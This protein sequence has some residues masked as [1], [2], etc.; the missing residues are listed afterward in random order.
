MIKTCLLGLGR[1]GMVVAEH[2]IKSPEFDLVSVI[3][4]QGSLKVNRKLNKFINTEKKI[5]IKD[6]GS[7]GSEAETKKIQVAIDFTTP[8]AVLKN[9]RTL[10]EKGVSLVIGTTGFNKMQL[11]ELR[12]IALENKIGLVYA[13]NI[14]TG[15]NLLLLIVKTLA[16]LIPNYDV[17]ISEFHHRFK[18][19]APSGTA[20]KIANEINNVKGIKKPRL[21][22]G[23]FGG[24]ERAKN[25]IGIHAIRAGGIIG[26]HTVLFSG[27]FDEIE[28]T[29]R[30][31][32]REVFAEGALRAAKFIVNKQGFY[33]MEDVLAQ[34]N[35]EKGKKNLTFE[36]G[37]NWWNQ[38][39]NRS[40]P[41][42]TEERQSVEK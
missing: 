20:V 19:D 21:I 5:I 42:L 9:A 22:Y 3:A 26:V 13:P 1:T 14:S 40:L 2:L 15:I 4:K 38:I 18:K 17:E 37:G 12:S 16:K 41:L 29:H 8:K 31:Y 28:I 23:R 10:A 32:S 7:L 25:E 35:K 30:S 27:N 34:E 6:A 11:N 36:K 39:L 24:V 33:S